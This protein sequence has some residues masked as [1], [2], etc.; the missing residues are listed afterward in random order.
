MTMETN[1]AKALFCTKTSVKNAHVWMADLIAQ[2]KI[3]EARNVLGIRLGCKVV[4]WV[5]NV[6]DSVIHFIYLV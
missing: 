1:M 5:L 3:V 4:L 2:L 6:P